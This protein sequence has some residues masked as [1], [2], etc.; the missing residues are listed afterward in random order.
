MA[1]FLFFWLTYIYYS[2]REMAKV[3]L[4]ASTRVAFVEQK[5]TLKPWAGSKPLTFIIKLPKLRKMEVMTTPQIMCTSENSMYSNLCTQSL[6]EM[7]TLVDITKNLR[8]MQI[9]SYNY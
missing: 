1:P 7:K 6:M 4:K 9:M 8:L 3:S 5:A 2:F